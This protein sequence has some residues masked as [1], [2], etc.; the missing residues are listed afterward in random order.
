[1]R[2][3]HRRS[4]YALLR[5]IK[6]GVTGASKL[7]LRRSFVVELNLAQVLEGEAG[8]LDILQS[9][10][11]LHHQVNSHWESNLPIN[12]RS[13]IIYTKAGNLRFY[14]GTCYREPLAYEHMAGKMVKVCNL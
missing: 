7:E 8:G 10:Q 14:G 2:L 4:K 6:E 3:E 11:I 9:T 12:A 1:M 13:V 5:Y